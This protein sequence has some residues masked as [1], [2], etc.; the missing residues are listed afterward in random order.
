MLAKVAI[1]SRAENM[2]SDLRFLVLVFTSFGLPTDAH[3]EEIETWICTESRYARDVLVTARANKEQET[4]QIEVAGVTHDSRFLV[5]GFERRWDFELTNE[6]TYDYAFVIKPNG[7][8][9][10]Y[11][12]SSTK[13]GETVSPSMRLKCKQRKDPDI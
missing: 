5:K 12:F 13:S 9:L 6:G 8:A 1:Q 11:D 4:G 2:K 7:D 10:Y 3:A